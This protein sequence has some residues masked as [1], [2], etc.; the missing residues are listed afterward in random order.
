MATNGDQA[1]VLLSKA[2]KD[3]ALVR[4]IWSDTDIVDEIIGF[5]AQQAIEKALT[6]RHVHRTRA[7]R[8]HSGRLTFGR[9][10]CEAPV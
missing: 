4:K 7:G 2:T 6:I 8:T 5:H 1:R 10:S 3:E 9:Q